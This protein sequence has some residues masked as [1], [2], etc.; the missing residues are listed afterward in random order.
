MRELWQRLHAIADR[1]PKPLRTRPPASEAAIRAAERTIGLDFPD[2]FRASLLVHDGQE[3]GD[4]DDDAFEWLPG[5]A[6]LASLERI[7][8]EWQDG[9]RCFEKFYEAGAVPEPI[10]DAELHHFMWHP[11][12]IPIAGNPWWDQD[13]TLLDFFP[14]PNGRAGQLAMFGKGCFGAVQGPSFGAAFEL[15]V[16]ALESGEWSFRDGQCLPRAKKMTWPKYVR[17]KLP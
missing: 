15:Y 5:Q 4:G 7:V 6:R 1:T 9:C 16:R 12:R 8:V 13:N 3:P 17:K 11:R 2:A 10:E 14:G